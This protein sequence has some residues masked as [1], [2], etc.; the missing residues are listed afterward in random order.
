MSKTYVPITELEMDSLLKPDKGWQK[1]LT[2]TTKEIVYFYDM[3]NCNIRVKVYSSIKKETGN[4]RGCGK[5]AIRVCAI[6]TNTNNGAYKSKRVNRIPG[7]EDR[8]KSRVI[9]II[10]HFKK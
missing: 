9:E 3:K 7:W 2:P 6:N 8:T 5:D 10:E 4:S 1:E